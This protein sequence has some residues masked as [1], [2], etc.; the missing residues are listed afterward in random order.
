MDDVD[1][2]LGYFPN[3]YFGYSYMVSKE[4]FGEGARIALQRIEEK[5]LLLVRCSVLSSRASIQMVISFIYRNYS[6]CCS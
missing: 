3:A 1:L 6:H 2:W 4:D 5:K